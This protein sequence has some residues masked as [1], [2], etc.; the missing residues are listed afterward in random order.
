PCDAAAA[1]AGAIEGVVAEPVHLGHFAHPARMHPVRVLVPGLADLGQPEFAVEHFRRDALGPRPHIGLA[2]DVGNAVAGERELAMETAVGVLVDDAADRVGIFAG[3]HAV[4]YHLGHRH[5]AA[6][7]FAAGFE[8]DRLGQ[9][10]LRL[11]AARLVEA[12]PLGPGHRP[13]ALAGDFAF[14]RHRLSSAYAVPH[15]H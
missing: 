7:G 4:E 5:L 3:E 8:V 9:A 6:H 13:L 11:G 10:L 12:E 1:G 2:H 14:G 15:H